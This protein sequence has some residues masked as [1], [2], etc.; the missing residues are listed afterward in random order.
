MDFHRNDALG[1]P[2]D[3]FI[4]DIPNISKGTKM[5]TETSNSI[6]QATEKEED[7]RPPKKRPIP[8]MLS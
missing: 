3:V 6:I 2:R 7:E 5:C 1:L 4:G 8:V